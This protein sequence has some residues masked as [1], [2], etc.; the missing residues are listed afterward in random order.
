MRSSMRNG[1][2]AAALGAVAGC[3]GSAPEP[4]QAPQREL[5]SA[6]DA[7]AGDCW[8]QAVRALVA[9]QRELGTNF[10]AHTSAQDTPREGLGNVARALYEQGLIPE[11]TIQALGAFLSSQLGLSIDACL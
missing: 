3:G 9:L 6:S 11:P 5:A 4:P 2:L 8:G 10:G 7:L 1:L